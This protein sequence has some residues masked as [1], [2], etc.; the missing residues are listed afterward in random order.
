MPYARRS[1]SPS[2]VSAAGGAIVLFGSSDRRTSSIN[3]RNDDDAVGT[4]GAILYGAAL[5][6]FA[7]YAVASGGDVNDDG[8]SD[9]ILGTQLFS[10][11]ILE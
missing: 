5:G 11:Y 4:S 6:D 9:L 1:Y 2:E 7:G 10:K 8:F 3:M